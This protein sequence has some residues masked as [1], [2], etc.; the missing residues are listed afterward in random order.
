MNMTESKLDPVVQDACNR[1]RT[2]S[3]KLRDAAEND[4]EPLTRA[5]ADI[6]FLLATFFEAEPSMKSDCLMHKQYLNAEFDRLETK[7]EKRRE[8]LINGPA[9]FTIVSIVIAVTSLLFK[10]L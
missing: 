1:L 8:G 10:V 9:A 4:S 3:Q 6:G 7:I 2:H 5:V